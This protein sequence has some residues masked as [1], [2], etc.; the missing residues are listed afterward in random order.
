MPFTGLKG[1][2]GR[3]GRGGHL[4]VSTRTVTRWVAAGA[5][6]GR[7]AYPPLP[8]DS[9][10]EGAYPTPVVRQQERDA[11]TRDRPDLLQVTVEILILKAPRLRG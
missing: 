11:M 3:G 9:Q 2:R 1:G 7:A 4:Q 10:E 8:L 6:P 5:F